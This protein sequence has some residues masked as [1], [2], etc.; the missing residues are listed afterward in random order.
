MR[1]L[2][3][4]LAGTAV[5]ATFSAF[6]ATSSSVAL[7][8]SFSARTSRPR[9]RGQDTV[10]AV[11]TSAGSGTD[12]STAYQVNALHDGHVSGGTE[13]PPLAMKWSR[14]LQGRISYP[15]ITNGRVFVTVAGDAGQGT[16]LYALDAADGHDVWGPIDLG[17]YFG[18]SALTA[19]D[20]R[21]YAVT[22]D[23]V[24]RAF[25]QATGITD[26]IIDLP[27]Q[28]SFTSPPTFANG[29]VYVGGA[30]SGGTLYAVRASDGALRW[31]ASVANGDHSSP[32][33]S[34]TSVFV[35]YACELTTSHDIADGHILWSHYAGCEGGGGRTPVLAHGQVWVRDDAGMGPVALDAATG[36]LTNSF[37]SSV[38]PAFDGSRMFVLDG[39]GLKARDATT[40]QLDWTFTGDGN[41]SSDPIVVNGYVYEGSTS[42]TLW[43]LDESTGQ[44]VWSANAGASIEHPDEHNA[45]PTTG[46][47]AGQGLVVVPA[48]NLLVAYGPATPVGEYTPLSPARVL[49]TRDG[50]GGHLGRLGADSSI[51]VPITGAHGVPASGV[52]AVT[53]NVTAVAPN[54]AG[55]LSV[56]PSGTPRPGTSNLNFVPDQVVPNLVTVP[57]GANGKV[58]IYNHTGSVHVVA[59]IA[60]FYADG[61][62]PSGTRFHAV[63]PTRLFDTRDGTGNV[64]TAP[65]GEGGTLQFKVTNKAGVP[66]NGVTGVILNVTA[67]APTTAGYLTAYPDDV[68]RPVASNLNFVAGQTVPNLV[69]V[70]VPA[71]G[72]VDFFN[73]LGSTQVVVDVLGYF[74]TDRSTEAGRLLT[75]A[76]TRVL[77]TRQ[78][79]PFPSPGKITAASSLKLDFTAWGDHSLIDSFIVN[80]TAT[81]PTSD[82]YIALFPSDQPVPFA[83]NLNFVA[84]QTVPNLAVVK[85]SASAGIESFN[86]Y[87]STHLVLDVFGAFTSAAWGTAVGS[88][89]ALGQPAL[90]VG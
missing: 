24:L 75:V 39:T 61:T 25:D 34:D 29:Y 73:Y 1:A 11:T 16:S 43:A 69:Q 63:E 5:V 36:A 47:A 53:L 83:S 23:G 33:V 65:V 40:L 74:D 89:S 41:L 58:S 56:W 21:V 51:D 88:L 26:W 35:S 77:D 80:A 37:S 10:D 62:G 64:P 59:D 38:A 12:E 18:F 68:A 84:G 8:Q 3:V 78:S 50:T 2:G 72:Y 7:S 28:Y 19:G 20:G 54:D 66:A 9:N 76:P 13:A 14:D 48:S 60:G 87:G 30:G 67:A 31:M 42:G 17:G 22:F 82:G 55:Y 44:P 90:S 57:V 15:V 71:N 86:A 27:Y 85:M 70:R 79:S 46:L 4:I 52:A 81:E 45:W 6:T 49:D 32:A